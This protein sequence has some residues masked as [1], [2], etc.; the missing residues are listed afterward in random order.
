MNAKETYKIELANISALI[1]QLKGQLT[2]HSEDFNNEPDKNKFLY[3]IEAEEV[4]K[5]LLGIN[6]F[7]SNSL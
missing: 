1:D 5:G 6:D 3:I 2:R 7:L 4:K